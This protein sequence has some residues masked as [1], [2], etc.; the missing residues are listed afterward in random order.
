MNTYEDIETEDATS[1]TLTQALT[2]LDRYGILE[3]WNDVSNTGSG[4]T[5]GNMNFSPV[6]RAFVDP[7]EDNTLTGAMG[8]SSAQPPTSPGQGPITHADFLPRNAVPPA[9][10][11]VGSVSDKK[12]PAPPSVK[13]V[14]PGQYGYIGPNGGQ[15]LVVGSQLSGTPVYGQE[16]RPLNEST[17]LL[18]QS[19]AGT[20]PKN[21]PGLDKAQ[22]I[23]GFVPFAGG[24]VNAGISDLRGNG[25]DSAVWLALGASGAMLSM[26]AIG[27]IRFGNNPNQ[28]YHTFRHIVD[29][30]MDRAAVQA[31][32]EADL[33]ANTS[34]ITA[35]LNARSITV[36]G[37]QITYHAFKLPSG[38][39]NVGRITLPP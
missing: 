4:K 12:N 5:P 14:P 20:L 27:V 2:G 29:A 34:A 33:A 1:G 25:T 22:A 6:G 36:A 16:G 9:S 15:V 28:D 10:G 21:S 39:I 30:G 38:V 19:A 8:P 26:A 23:I 35:G 17:T 32:I 31:A 3:Y 37:Q 11:S 24:F 18:P 7:I 13:T